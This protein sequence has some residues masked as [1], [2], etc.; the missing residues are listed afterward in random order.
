MSSD[1]SRLG[2]SLRLTTKLAAR[3]A[4]PFSVIKKSE[5]FWIQI[6]LQDAL[7][8]ENLNFTVSVA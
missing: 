4:H 5:K 2:V 6:A 8:K 1:L 7:R 3:W